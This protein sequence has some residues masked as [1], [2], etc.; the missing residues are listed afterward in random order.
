[1]REQIEQTDNPF[2]RRDLAA[3]LLEVDAT[4]EVPTSSPPSRSTGEPFQTVPAREVRPE[5]RH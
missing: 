4:V 1:M 3:L 5:T 2:I